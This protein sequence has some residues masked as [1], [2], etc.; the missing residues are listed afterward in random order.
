MAKVFH[1]IR[2]PIHIFIR[3]DSEERK[4]L[5][6]PAF[7]RLRHIHQ[8][9]MTYLIYPSATHK[10]FEH[11]LGVM[12]LAT[13]IFDMVTAPHHV[14]GSVSELLPELNNRDNLAYWRRVLRMAALCHDVGHLPFSHA[15]ESELLPSGYDHEVLTREIL[16]SPDMQ[17]IWKSLTPPLRGQD[18]VK[19]A[20]G[21]AKAESS[22][23]AWETLLSEIITGD[24]FGADRMDYLLRDSHHLGVAYGRFDHYR[25]IDTLRIVRLPEEDEKLTLGVE[26]GG[27]HSAEAL[28]LARYFM[29]TQVYFHPVRRIYDIHL[30]DFLTIW[31]QGKGCTDG[32][33]P[34]QVSDFLKLTDDEILVALLEAASDDTKPAH[35]P[36]R[37][38]VRREHFKLFYQR[39]PSDIQ[40]NPEACDLIHRAACQQFG[41]ENVR[42]DSYS[43]RRAAIVFPVLRYDG[44][45]VD[46][47]K[48][49]EL[50]GNVPIV[51]V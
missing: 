25:L 3:L 35:E 33:F 15:A 11:S 23:T 38:I 29:F 48:L 22:M 36:A 7:Q 41:S 28:A 4:V 51:S 40:E 34:T 47:T 37:R 10:R 46:S 14:D 49:S 44:A 24:A 13:R 1:E 20:L 6:S 17:Q 8:L 42:R 32:K 30:R 21:P 26:E 43:Q 19:I 2:D 39:D 16:L 18:V 5:D 45:V 12:E 31:L 9:G 27:L 50:L